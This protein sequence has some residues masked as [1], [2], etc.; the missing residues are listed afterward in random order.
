MRRELILL[1]IISVAA[2]SGMY[3]CIERYDVSVDTVP[4]D[5]PACKKYVISLKEAEDRRQTLATNIPFNLEIF[6]GV[7]G[8]AM[9]E[10]NVQEFS[11]L[12]RGQIGCFLSHVQLWE[13]IVRDDTG[14]VCIF[15]DDA[16][17]RGD[18]A[19]NILRLPVDAELVFLGHCAESIGEKIAGEERLH[20]SV[21]PRC[22]FGYLITKDAAKR[23]AEYMRSNKHNMPI[24]EIFAQLIHSGFVRAYSYQPALV[25]TSGQPSYIN[26]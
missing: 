21:Y 12:S 16:V 14:T 15:E 11:N 23:L 3:I 1:F 9:D 5:F 24:D 6:D 4:F 2:L 10:S 17:I 25:D 20:L 18:Q 22:M 13:K 7:N 26:R 19:T 8:R